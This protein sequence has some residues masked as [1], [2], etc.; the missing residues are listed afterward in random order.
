M[1]QSIHDILTCFVMWIINSNTTIIL[2]QCSQWWISARLQQV[3]CYGNGVTATPL[4]WQWSYCSLA[5]SHQHD[6]SMTESIWWWSLDQ[7]FISNFL[8]SNLFG[9]ILFYIFPYG[10]I[11]DKWALINV[12]APNR[13]QAIIKA[14]HSLM[15]LCFKR[16]QLVHE[17]LAQ[18][19]VLRNSTFTNIYMYIWYI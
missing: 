3:H 2:L 19:L 16:P 9:S 15:Y 10:L 18:L 8:Q 6:V 17:L 5:L 7:S 12:L 1:I 4:L 13:W 14:I 11:D